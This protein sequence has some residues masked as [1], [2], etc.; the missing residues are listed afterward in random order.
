[1]WEDN[2]VEDRILH[3]QWSTQAVSK[4]G[5]VDQV[6]SGQGDGWLRATRAT[7]GKKL[8]EFDTNPRRIRLAAHRATDHRHTR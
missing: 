5:G 3:G 7:T 2:S 4:I 6:V 8:W 1:V